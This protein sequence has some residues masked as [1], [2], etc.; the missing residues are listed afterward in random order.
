MKR[1]TL[2]LD[3]KTIKINS[4][5]H[6]RARLEFGDIESMAQSISKHGL[7]HPIVVSEIPEN[8][9]T[10]DDYKY[11]LIA[12]ER[13]L[14]SC[15]LLGH[16]NISAT[17]IDGTDEL[18]R[19]AMELE[20]NVRR[21]DLSWQEQQSCIFQLHQIKQREAFEMSKA[22]GDK[23]D[24][25]WTIRDTAEFLE[26]SVGSVALAVKNTEL[27]Q[28][29]P[30]LKKKVEKMP[31]T[32]AGTVLRRILK[33][34]ESERIVK[35][36]NV[37]ISCDLRLGNCLDLIDDIPDN[38]IDM[39][40]TD[41]PFASQGIVDNASSSG[42]YN[43]DKDNV[44]NEETMLPLL[45]ALFKKL[46]RKLKAGSHC[47]IFTGMGR[48]YYEQI[49]MLRNHGF[50]VDELP[51]IWFKERPS[52]M[53]RDFSYT[54]SYEAIIFCHYK[55]KTKRLMK[56]VK[57]VFSVPAIAGQK[58]VHPLQRPSFLIEQIIE[59]SS[60]VGDTILDC[61]AGSGSTLYAA[62]KLSRK[63]IGFELF[64]GNYYTALEWLQETEGDVAS[65]PELVQ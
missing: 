46:T 45:D 29:R 19:K 9:K 11:I 59:N 63:S 52:V 64:E 18:A 38:S 58:K 44:S 12:G 21:K 34:E 41:P 5:A 40:F 49:L 16:A 53:Q 31:A 27:L 54:S 43:F 8:E 60:D 2:Q 56:P 28:T 61:F 25:N 48:M 24:A 17:V 32:A 39:L 1:K 22:T 55:E 33:R 6:E 57:N 10:S 23:Q 47:Y 3:I 62:R 42:A 65:K 14:R 36:S 13:R 7:M 50:L 30:D 37:A 15:V 35:N 51:L 20:E 26:K 4:N